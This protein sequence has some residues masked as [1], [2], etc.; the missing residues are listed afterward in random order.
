MVE[1][2]L[3]M[4]PNLVY[5]PSPICGLIGADISPEPKVPDM[6]EVTAI[7]DSSFETLTDDDCIGLASN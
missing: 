7:L 1:T 3:S 6:T 4:D 5:S 2:T